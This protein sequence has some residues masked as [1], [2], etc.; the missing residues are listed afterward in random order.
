MRPVWLALALAVGGSAAG[1]AQERGL[2]VGLGATFVAS[3]PVLAGIGPSLWVPLGDQMA[4]AVLGVAGWR[5]R[6]WV[7]RGELTLQFRFPSA[8][9]HGVGWYLEAGTACVTG[10]GGGGYLVVGAGVEAPL[11]RRGIFWAEIGAAG[12]ARLATGFRTT[13]G[14]KRRTAA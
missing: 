5:D 13:L 4:V 9:P 1:V 7:G 12:G 14:R 10:P 11:G 2:A 8:R 3:D 6:S